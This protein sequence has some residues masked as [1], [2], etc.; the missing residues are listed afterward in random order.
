MSVADT[1]V[2]PVQPLIL[3][4]EDE[5]ILGR[6][7]ARNLNALG[8]RVAGVAST[9]AQAVAYAGEHRP[10]LVLMDIRLEGE[11]DGITAAAEIR[12]RWQTP[13]VFLSAHF[14]DESL[15]RARAAGAHG[16]LLK[17]FRTPELNAT[18]QLA[19]SQQRLSHELFAEH[20]WLR[21]MLGCLSDAV[22]ATDATGCVRYMNATAEALTGWTEPAA[23]GRAI[24]EVYTLTTLSGVPLEQCQLRKALAGAAPAER[25]RFWMHARGG[26]PLP[27]EDVAAPIVKDGQI[28]GA[29]TMFQDIS[30]RLAAE[31][32]KERQR[33]RLR[34]RFETT[35]AELG[36]TRAELE[37]LSRHLM[38]AQEEERRRVARE[39][40]DD[41]GQQ[42]AL[43]EL[44]VSR[45]QA[46]LAQIPDAAHQTLAS[47]VARSRELSAGLRSVSHRLHPSVLE[48]LGLQA[49]LRM[50]AEEHRRCGED[51][52]LIEPGPLPPLR[53]EATTALYRIA[54]EALRNARRHAPQAPV[55]VT[56]GVFTGPPPDPSTGPSPSPGPG[57]SDELRLCI[58]DAGPGFDPTRGPFGLGLVS[59][60]ERAR[61]VGGRT[62]IESA[63]DE[64]T[65]IT[66]RLPLSEG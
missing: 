36:H 53:P 26:L 57:P 25:Q 42:T 44:E 48:D 8:Y 50:L 15:V 32:R 22:I 1:T 51:I 64:G 10:D 21:Q 59:M 27:V 43:L 39:L 63:P 49:A 5:W 24:E 54:Q 62:E 18:I 2:A 31:V 14:S 16:Y 17:P 6:D 58:E 13:V 34:E 37:A 33:H 28:I 29:V 45:L 46:Q 3:V 52:S 11:I 60:K 23:L 47:L 40:H 9:G 7:L 30:V 19:L 20:A 12:R 56:L 66:V 38:T 65:R 55:R 61:S 4:V 35:A 41:L